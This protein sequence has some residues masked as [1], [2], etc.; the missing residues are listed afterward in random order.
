MLW[1]LRFLDGQGFTVNGTILFQ[2]NK[3]VMLLERNGRA[4]SSKRTRHILLRYYFVKEHVDSGDIQ[5]QYCPTK[6]MWGDFFTKP[7]QGHLFLVQRDHVMN[8]DSSS[9]Y[10]SSHRSVLRE[11]TNRAHGGDFT[12]LLEPKEEVV[13]TPPHSL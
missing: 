8:I 13:A 12:P 2:D 1:T 4:S 6:E 7:T 11:P 9:P 10:H 3:S 5:V